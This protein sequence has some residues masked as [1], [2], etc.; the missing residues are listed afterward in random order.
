MYKIVNWH[1]GRLPQIFVLAD[2]Y[3]HAIA[4][5]LAVAMCTLKVIRDYESPLNTDERF[6]DMQNGHRFIVSK[7]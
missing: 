7:V 1:T 6:F 2:S 4:Q 3:Q 5:F